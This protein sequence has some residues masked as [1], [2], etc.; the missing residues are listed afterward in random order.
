MERES[1]ELKVVASLTARGMVVEVVGLKPRRLETKRTFRILCFAAIGMAKAC[2][3]N[4]E[5]LLDEIHKQLDLY[6]KAEQRGDTQITEE[7]D[8][9]RDKAD[10]SNPL[11][12]SDRYG[13]SLCSKLGGA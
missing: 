12:C 5:Y 6:T 3:L 10:V 9:V 2:A 7:F 11:L 8:E 1:I 13:K 4:D